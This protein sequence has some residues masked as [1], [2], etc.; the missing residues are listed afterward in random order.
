MHTTQTKIDGAARKEIRALVD[1]Y[2]GLTVKFGLDDNES[3][4]RV[5]LGYRGKSRT[6]YFDRFTRHRRALPDVIT[7][8]KRTIEALGVSSNGTRVGTLGEVFAEVQA[9]KDNPPPMPEPKSDPRPYPR[10]EPTNGLAAKRNTFPG[11]EPQPDAY[12]PQTEER[13][14]MTQARR[15]SDHHETKANGRLHSGNQGIAAEPV[16]SRRGPRARLKQ[17]DVII[18]SRLMVSCG[19]LD[20]NARVYTYHKDYSD[21]TVRDTINKKLNVAVVAKFRR[22]NFGLLPTEARRSLSKDAHIANLME[23]VDS[24]TR[25]LEAQRQATLDI[26]N[27]LERLEK[28]LGATPT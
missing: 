8:A 16:D 25:E 18:F 4:V 14:Q 17:K 21:E 23:A 28:E 9:R 3:K 5:L 1:Q 10:V 20:E 2:R 27:R 13:S 6:F 11:D 24:L 22:E 12:H 15:T 26:G 7:E 19:T